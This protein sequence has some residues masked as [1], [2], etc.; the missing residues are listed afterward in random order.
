MS[1]DLVIGAAATGLVAIIGALIKGKLDFKKQN[2]I[3]VI[4]NNDQAFLLYKSMVVNLQE[5]ISNI[6][7]DTNKLEAEHMICREKNAELKL[8]IKYLLEQNAELKSNIKIL[9]EKLEQS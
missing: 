3:E 4:S 9:K 1:I 5:Q 2:S 8:E 6:Q 7:K